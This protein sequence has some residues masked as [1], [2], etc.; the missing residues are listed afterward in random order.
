MPDFCIYAVIYGHKLQKIFGKSL[1]S[2]KVYGHFKMQSSYDFF[3]G[4]Y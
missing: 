4:T 2:A 3:I 1:D